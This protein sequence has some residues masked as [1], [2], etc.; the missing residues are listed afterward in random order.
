LLKKTVRNTYGY[1][2]SG[3]LQNEFMSM[4]IALGLVFGA[5]FAF[6]VNL[7]LIDIGLAIGLAIGLI[8]GKERENKL[9]KEGKLY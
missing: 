8:I 5:T 2:E 4:G 1:I 7:A 3:T 6:I 9:E